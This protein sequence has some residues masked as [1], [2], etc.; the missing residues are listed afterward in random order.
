MAH[1]ITPS[2][3]FRPA[4]AIDLRDKD[5]NL[6]AVDDADVIAN[7]RLVIRKHEP[8]LTAH[9]LSRFGKAPPDI[10]FGSMADY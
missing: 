2:S 7:N 5:D 10:A 4:G 1:L 9:L 8:C 6:A 3:S